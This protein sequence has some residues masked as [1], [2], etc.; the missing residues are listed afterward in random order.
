MEP[1]RND[2]EITRLGTGSNLSTY[3][4]HNSASR[5]QMF[6][7]HLTQTPPV[8]GST[9][10]RILTGAE[11]DYGKYTFKFEMPCDAYVI[12]VIQKYPR[13]VG[14]GSIR[15]NPVTAIVYENAETN[16]IGILELEKYH[17]MHTDFGF[18]YVYNEEALSQLAPKQPIAKG[19]VFAHSPSLKEG[20]YCY[21]L[22]TQIAFMSIPQVI[23][24]GFVVSR[25]YLERIAVQTVESRTSEW[26]KEYYPLNL[27][28]DENHYKPFPDIG[29][30][31][32]PDGLLFVLRKYDEL[33]AFNEMSPRDLMPDNIDYIYDKLVYATPGAT[34]YDIDVDRDFTLKVQDTPTGMDAQTIKY[35]NAREAYYRSLLE[36]YYSLR[37][38]RKDSLRLEPA[39]HRLLIEAIGGVDPAKGD[40]R[41]GKKPTGKIK[42]SKIKR[43]HRRKPLDNWRV[44]VKYAKRTVPTIGYK[45]TDGQGS[46]GVKLLAQSISNG[47]CKFL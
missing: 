14:E 20:T 31:I 34:V 41:T 45:L 32:R 2:L 3:V 24:D 7:S 29:D 5:Q 21:G 16:E 40:I 42:T 28:G 33:S 22:E 26:G 15:E 35:E 43:M 44:T 13:K 30:T 10:K 27:Y 46:K 17:C 47:W 37:R 4:G 38:V 6:C 23:E 36:V 8:E 12:K 11:E 18:K 19:T 9:P 39:F 1:A 25:S